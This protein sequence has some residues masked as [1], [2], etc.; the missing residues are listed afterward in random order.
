MNLFDYL[1][2]G[3][4]YLL[5]DEKEDFIQVVA[6]TFLG[7]VVR[8]QPEGIKPI[9]DHEVKRRQLL[10]FLYGAIDCAL[11]DFGRNKLFDSKNAEG[12]LKENNLIWDYFQ[13]ELG[14][15]IEEVMNIVIVCSDVQN[16]N[17]ILGFDRNAMHN[18]VV[19]GGNALNDWIEQVRHWISI[20]KDKEEEEYYKNSAS[21]GGLLGLLAQDY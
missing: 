21:A 11:L 14:Y 6:N 15:R 5:E 20:S 1:D 4:K 16:P 18:L 10:Y 17:E 19:N 13:E 8:S 2:S 9:M 7:D 3:K 12:L